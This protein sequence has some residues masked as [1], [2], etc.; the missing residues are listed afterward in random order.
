MTTT[1]R[2]LPG[3]PAEEIEAIFRAAPGKEIG[4]G[5]FDSPESS[6]TLAGNAFGFFLHRAG[7]LPTLPGCEQAGQET[8]NI[9]TH[10]E[11]VIGRY[12]P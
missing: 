10:A 8:R 2:W 7:V 1:N 3:V 4:R 6:A 5:K 11:S 12:A 9:R